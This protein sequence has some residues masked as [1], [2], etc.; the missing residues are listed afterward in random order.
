MNELYRIEA[1]HFTAGVTFDNQTPIQAA[2][3]IGYALRM[4]KDKFLA[5]CK[6]KG[7]K[8]ELVKG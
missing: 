3:I 2:P 6:A 7:W 1:P 8:V 5:Y 4:T